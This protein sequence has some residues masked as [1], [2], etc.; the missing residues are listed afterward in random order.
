MTN[1]TYKD[2]PSSP[3]MIEA[4]SPAY[5]VSPERVGHSCCGGCCDM[6]RAVIIVNLIEIVLT[7]LA[8]SG[9]SDLVAS[10]QDGTQQQSIDGILIV[11]FLVSLTCGLLGVFGAISFSPYMVSVALVFNCIKFCLAVTK[12][13][14]VAMCVIGLIVYPHLLFLQE[15][16]SG[17]MTQENYPNEAQRCCCV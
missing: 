11:V 7:F 9:A 17:V 16:K 15:M 14:P 5:V 12:V 8:L 4:E 2:V 1:P 10:Q 3:M 6:R 13:N